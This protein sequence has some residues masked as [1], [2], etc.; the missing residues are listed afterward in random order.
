LTKIVNEIREIFVSMGF[1]EIE[2]DYVQPCLW[3]MDAL[4]VPQ[5]HPARDMQDTFY[6]DGKMR[7]DKKIAG[8]IKKI[9]ENGGN[10]GSDGWGI[11]W[12][13]DEAE[14]TVLRTHTTVN[15]IRYLS[16]HP[17]PPLK[18]FTVGR[19]FRRENI[20]S[21]HLP[22]FTQIEGIVMEKAAN[23]NMLVGILKEFYKR[24]GFEKIKIRPSYFPF[25]EPS[26]EVIVEYDDK[27]L[28]MGGAG[29]FRPEVTAPFNV[30]AP[31]LA[32]GLG[33]ERLA[34]IRLGLKDIRELYMSDIEWLRR[35]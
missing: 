30:K 14:K 1:R 33:L 18:V 7:V 6:I 34:M 35:V 13:M 15:T 10:T 27:L 19:N 11:A 31:V 24:I 32:W 4:F 12:D 3:N 21:T 5:D 25:T 20:D 8:K 22:E 16:E 23:F 29:I 9:H 26:L 28:E 17:E 2:Y